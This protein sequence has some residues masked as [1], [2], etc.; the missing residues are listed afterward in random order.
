MIVTLAGKLNVSLATLLTLLFPLENH[1]SQEWHYEICPQIGKG[2]LYPLLDN[3]EICCI[4]ILLTIKYKGFDEL[5]SQ[6]LK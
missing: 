1:E 4:L 2:F 3:E 5:C 6:L